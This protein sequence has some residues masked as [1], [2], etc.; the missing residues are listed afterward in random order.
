MK[1][2]PFKC[3]NYFKIGLN[4][5]FAD[6]I[7]IPLE[8]LHG[9][10]AY[11]G[12]RIGLTICKKNISRHGRSIF[13]KSQEGQGSTFTLPEIQSPV[14]LK[15]PLRPFQGPII[16]NNGPLNKDNYFFTIFAQ[17]SRRVTTLLNTGVAELV[18]STQK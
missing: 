7:F 4:E 2:T 15:K 10:S 1:P 17:V 14:H 12:T 5:K 13:V 11:E 16:S 9:I 8:K 6:Q 3:G 18:L